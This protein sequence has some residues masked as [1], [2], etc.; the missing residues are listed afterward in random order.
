MQ[1]QTICGKSVT[2]S[3]WIDKQ[4]PTKEKK[5]LNN[6]NK[7]KGNKKKKN[8]NK[9]NNKNNK[10]NNNNKTIPMTAAYLAVKNEI[11]KQFKLF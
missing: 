11:F 4:L 9:N 2:I 6:N 1:Q 3:H 8:N 10:N 7:N 5:T